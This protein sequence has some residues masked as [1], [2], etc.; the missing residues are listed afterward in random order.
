MT[1]RRDRLLFAAVLLLGALPL[2]G[3][4]YTLRLGTTAC[5]YAVM[6]VSWNVIGGLAGYPSFATAGFFG[7]GAYVGGVTLAKGG[8]LIVALALAGG[9]AFGGAMLLGA[10]L[11]RLRGHYFAIASLAVAEVLRELTN[12]ATGLTGGGMGL[13]IPLATSTGGGIVAEASFF[14]F[15]MWGLLVLTLVIVVAAERSRLGFGLA[16]IRQNE[17]AADMIGVN[18]TL[19][20]SLAFALSGVF[21]AMAGTLYAGWVHY[22]EPTDVYDI[23][24]AVKPIVMVLLGGLGSTAGAVLGAFAFFGISEAVWRNYLQIH[25]GMLGF[26][27][28]LLLLFLPRGIISIGQ[29][30][31]TLG[32]GRA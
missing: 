6:A 2:V 23:L 3:E 27:I 12:S 1:P 29:R 26:L 5:M 24:F 31:K 10:V 19:Y 13:N 15:A 4:P 28:V 21:V 18:A 16:C 22:I 7:L 32:F 11:L 20:K 30:L 25:S 14:Y 17:S 9:M 8:G